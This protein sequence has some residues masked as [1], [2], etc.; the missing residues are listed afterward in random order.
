MREK[1]A[2]EFDS[3]ESEP[4]FLHEPVSLKLSGPQFPD[5]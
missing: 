3:R 4:H 5:L 1:E 2:L